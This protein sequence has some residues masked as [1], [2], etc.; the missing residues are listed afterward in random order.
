MVELESLLSPIL[1]FDMS[2]VFLCTMFLRLALSSFL[3]S[4][5]FGLK[6]VRSSERYYCHLDTLV[7]GLPS[8]A[9]VQ[10]RVNERYD[11]LLFRQS[12][13]SVKPYVCT[14]CDEFLIKKEDRQ[15]V[16]VD[17]LKSCQQFLSW[18][19][20]ENLCN[21]S[22]PAAVKSEYSWNGDRKCYK[23][24]LSFVKTMALS[25]RG[26]L[27]KPAGA[28]KAGFSCC[29]R[30]SNVLNKKFLPRHAILNNNWVG[31]PP[32]CLLEL[33]DVE[34]AFLSPIKHYGY[35]FTWTGGRQKNLKGSLT[36]M[37]VAKRG[38]ATGLATLKDLGLND[39]VITLFAGPMTENQK[40]RA[41]ME[42]TIRP[43]KLECALNWLCKNNQRWA[44]VDPQQIMEQVKAREPV[45]YDHSSTVENDN[46]NIEEKA[47]FTVYYPD[48]ATTPTHGG[49][50]EAKEFKEFAKALA[51]N[52]FDKE[53][54]L[55]LQKQFIK[56]GESDLL[57]DACLLQFPYGR[58]SMDERRLLKD[59]S[60][61]RDCDMFEFF[62]HLSLLSQPHF[63][64][65]LVQLIMCSLMSKERLLK[66]SRLQL[67]GKTAASNLADGLNSSDVISAI[68]GRRLNN[69]FAGTETSRRF[70]NAV[71]ATARALPH[72]NEAAKSARGNGEAMQHHLGMGS[73]FLTVT[74]DDENSVLIL[75]Y[76]GAG[77]QDENYEDLS[78]AKLA[79][80]VKNRRELRIKFPGL[81]AINFELLLEILMEEVVGW[82]CKNHCATGQPGFFGVPN[83]LSFAIEEQGRKTLHVHMTIWI[84]LFK[85]IQ[86][87]YF[88][89]R[90][91]TND[92]V[93]AEK[94]LSKYHEH[95][96]STKLFPQTKGEL[97]TAFGHECLVPCR[98]RL[99]PV[100]IDD[101]G[102][103]NLRHIQAHKDTDGVFAFCPHDRCEKTWTY[104]DMISD[105]MRHCHQIGKRA[106]VPVY[107]VNLST[108]LGQDGS[109]I[110]KARS[111]A[112]MLDFQLNGTEIPSVC[113]D[114]VCNA[115]VSCHTRN[116]FK[117]KKKGKAGRG[118]KCGPS[119]ECRYRLPDLPRSHA[120]VQCHSEMD[121]Y[122]WDGSSYQ[123]P[124]SQIAPKRGKYDLFQNCCCEPVSHSKF[125]CNSNVA[126]I[127]DGPIGQYMHKYQEKQ[128]QAEE[129][130]DYHEVESTIKRMANEERVYED[131]RKE[132]L[133]K[134]CRA[135]FAH[136]KRNVISPCFASYLIRHSSRFYYS[137]DFTYCPLK[138]LVRIHNK[139]EV[140]G[141]LKYQ[142]WGEGRCFFENQALNYLCRH[143]SLED[144]S[145]KIYTE[146]YCDAYVSQSKEEK[147]LRYMASTIAGFSHP[148]VIKS[149]QSANKGKCSHGSMMREEPTFIRVSQWMFPD[150]AEFRENILT[151]DEKD[152]NQ[153]MEE[154]AQ[155]VLCLFMPHRG[156]QDLMGEGSF[157]YIRKFRQVHRSDMQRMSQGLEAQCFSEENTLF[158]Q[159]LQNC[160]SN[161]LRYKITSDELA[162]STHP[163]GCPNGVDGDNHGEEEDTE[164][165]E[166]A[167]ESFVEQLNEDYDI[168]PNTDKEPSF[169]NETLRNFKF[170]YVRDKGTNNCGYKG[171]LPLVHLPKEVDNFVSYS[172]VNAARVRKNLPPLPT[173]RRTYT[174]D[175]IVKV[176][177][178][179]TIPAHK[180]V[181]KDRTIEVTG[182]TGTVKS[183]REWSKA[184]FGTDRKQ[185]RAFEILVASF[186]LTFYEEASE[187]ESD[188]AQQGRSR[189][190]YREMKRALLK[191]R[192]WR[193]RKEK[194][195]ICLLHGPGG[196]GKSTVINA[197][198]AYASDFCDLLGHPFT[199]RTIIITAM[200][201]VAATLLKGETAHMVLGLNR[202]SVQ[203]EESDEWLDA[204]LLIIDEISF[205]SS[206]D[207]T[208]MHENCKHFMQNNYSLYGGLNMVFAGDY[209]QLEPVKREPVYKKGCE[210]NEFQGA[211]NCFIELEGKWRF[212]DDKAWGD[213][214]S[215]FR[216]GCP[217]VEDIE[218]INDKCYRRKDIPDGIQVATYMNKDRDA[219]NSAIFDDLCKRHNTGDAVLKGVCLIFMDEL[220][221][222]NSSQVWVPIMSNAVK[223]YFYE[224]CNE[225]D[226]K[227][228]SKA[229]GRVDPCLKVYCDCP[230][231]HTQNSSV[232]DG[233]ANGSRILAKQV[234]LKR[235][236]IPFEL[237][238]DC[239]TTIHAM[240]AS[241][242][243]HILVEH[244]C[245]DIVP[246][247]FTIESQVTSFHC[248]MHLEGEKEWLALRG[249]QFPI[250]SNSCTTGHK[251]QGC[252]VED[253]L[254]NDWNFG[255]NWVYVV[256]SRVKTMAG[257]YI[258]QKLPLKLEKYAKS[259]EM[260]DMIRKF[261]ETINY[262]A[263]SDS[264][265]KQLEKIGCH[266]VEAGVPVCPGTPGLR[267]ERA[268]DDVNY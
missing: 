75:V 106:A 42:S 258:R 219:I 13:G 186:L 133:R 77:L 115:H 44:D 16:T 117:C 187:D 110:P 191:L 192:G 171:D 156:K 70:L 142:P 59:G 141:M 164:V 213:I 24:D 122:S 241:Q 263:I 57:L 152:F 183:I 194:N 1:S 177:F 90:S 223:R 12:D 255:A 268:D 261:A 35:C 215:R 126:L 98:Q 48:G 246:R 17:K 103:R 87:Q 55:N 234:K 88:F 131:D 91:N 175:E 146:H 259:Q 227:V 162:A 242:V 50:E 10:S 99:L 38:I 78:D 168:Q 52:G 4:G 205:A 224:N 184:A 262:E 225:D 182:A 158:L 150:T 200:S 136:N 2:I 198:K 178:I 84:A 172:T 244:E 235:G 202:D 69:R 143:P 231:M 226:C 199:N 31:A 267:N 51:E 176:H 134:I 3:V 81:A 243:E 238:L 206:E 260:K 89:P 236:E 250:I 113:M 111:Y 73:V 32:P 49:C 8:S 26:I 145:L 174:V 130:A 251:L 240:Y 19:Y 29:Q 97:K 102:L 71:D 218:L 125:T 101:Q 149:N 120:T 265:Y 207:F 138:D 95:V 237:R 119:C 165:E 34:L 22:V 264:E 61:T 7:K 64:R 211:L 67:R 41:K 139:Q 180:Q 230:M 256:L 212:R 249:T 105:Y 79:E 54:E 92:R 266:R 214:M 66:S 80:N 247:R 216:E 153:K 185:Q 135:S 40:K 154:Y 56:G 14:I 196:S 166:V 157:P 155:L 6:M 47:V 85:A 121:W 112:K 129:T 76:S 62:E 116:C 108:S 96:A 253:I 222:K 74:F 151:C 37:R 181:W 210:S 167:Y 190:V 118:H 160:R 144:L 252:T 104:E 109:L 5:F 93:L 25:P 245:E 23:G 229:R 45:M 208:K 137:L 201:G 128:N 124:L 60:W 27:E 161:T 83:G 148:S 114:A 204:R 65:P 220:Y 127:L 228:N 189:G 68:N 28:K 82:D 39:H 232:A 36:F 94:I 239:G 43:A 147:V 188:A 254:A 58:G 170:V 221:S 233:E 132:A 217:T 123:I 15:R 140:R 63:Q 20:M 248:K 9:E 257:L 11:S 21:E 179:K 173:E 193:F 53:F 18:E 86:R 163:Y 33:T 107:D 100:V 169:L 195:L 72:T 209:S 203:L 197:V 30:C 159:N 46:L